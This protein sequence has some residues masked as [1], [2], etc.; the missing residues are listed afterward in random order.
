[1]YPSP[2][3]IVACPGCKKRFLIGGYDSSMVGATYWSDG[4][5]EGPEWPDLPG[6]VVRCDDCSTYFIAA[7]N[8]ERNVNPGTFNFQT[9]PGLSDITL[10]DIQVILGDRAILEELSQQRVHS[11]LTSK[12]KDMQP[13]LEK[14]A[15]ILALEISR[16]SRALEVCAL[17]KLNHLRRKKKKLSPE[18]K[19]LFERF[20]SLALNEPDEYDDWKILQNAEWYRNL[21][22][23]QFAKRALRRV[24]NPEYR[25]ARRKLMVAVWLR[26]R[27]LFIVSRHRD[28]YRRPRLKWLK[29]LFKR[30]MSHD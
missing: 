22:R 18:Q 20:A 28:Y 6:P 13:T 8:I 9:M 19:K 7:A 4:F 10:V 14:D 24:H 27:D 21:G 26:R 29:R 1:M 30:F 11:R 2:L 23:F 5:I 15:E 3:Q 12:K 16:L 25:K 17:Y